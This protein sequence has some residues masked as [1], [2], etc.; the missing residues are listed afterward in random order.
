MLDSSTLHVHL[1]GDGTHSSS[2][3]EGQ[4]KSHGNPVSMAILR[5]MLKASLKNQLAS[6]GHRAQRRHWVC[7]HQKCAIKLKIGQVQRS[8]PYRI[9]LRHC[10]S[11]AMRACLRKKRQPPKVARSSMG[12]SAMGADQIKLFIMRAAFLMPR[13]KAASR[14]SCACPSISAQTVLRAKAPQTQASPRPHIN[15]STEGV[16]VG[17][18]RASILHRT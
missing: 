12:T 15:R 7:R 11:R 2:N 6:G 18:K 16:E 14:E 8:A 13:L 5:H 4:F 9:G 1:V 10:R 3:A 17:K